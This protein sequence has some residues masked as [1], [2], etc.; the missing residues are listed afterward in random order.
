LYALTGFEP[1]RYTPGA[2]SRPWRRFDFL[3]LARTMKAERRHELQQNELADRLGDMIATAREYSQAIIGTVLLVVVVLG[4]YLYFTGSSRRKED[5]SWNAYIKA[6]DAA[7]RPGGQLNPLIELTNQYPTTTGGLWGRLALAD[8]QFQNGVTQLFENRAQANLFLTSAVDNYAKLRSDTSDRMLQARAT[9]GLARSYE[10][11]NRLS[12]ARL[13][14][15]ALIARY[16][17]DVWV[18]EA[19]RRSADLERQS[20]RDFYDWFARQ[21]VKPTPTEDASIP[22]HKPKFDMRSLPPEGP[23]FTDKAAD[24][25]AAATDG[26]AAS[27]TSGTGTPG[28]GIPGGSAPG[29]TSQP[30]ADTVPAKSP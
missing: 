13:E 2:S 18:D 25:G 28:T 30:P 4:A 22:G 12:N 7:M 23:V 20:T 14:Y 26:A 17:N 1:L 19:K 21:D 3:E 11:L 15:D 27:T 6:T 9:M 29:S 5:A 8:I 24:S 10:A 16:P